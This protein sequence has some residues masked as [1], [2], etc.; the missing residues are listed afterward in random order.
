[1]V[2]S[3]LTSRNGNSGVTKISVGRSGTGGIAG[4]RGHATWPGPRPGCR[5]CSWSTRRPPSASG[6]SSP[7]TSATKTPAAPNYKAACRFSECCEGC[8]LDRGVPRRDGAAFPRSYLR[9]RL[10][11]HAPGCKTQVSTE[12]SQVDRDRTAYPREA[13][14]RRRQSHGSTRVQLISA[15]GAFHVIKPRPSSSASRREPCPAHIT[16][17]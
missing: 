14:Q 5:R 10:P 17:P 9:A 6:S 13:W 7:P 2:G 11:G 3:R 4:T 12:V 8:G 16:L 1:M 15:R